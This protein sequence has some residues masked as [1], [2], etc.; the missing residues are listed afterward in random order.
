MLER[1]LHLG[2]RVSECLLFGHIDAFIPTNAFVQSCRMVGLSLLVRCKFLFLIRWHK[3]GGG[4]FEE[5]S[6]PCWN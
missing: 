6:S 1:M 3:L 2:E 5:G 4:E